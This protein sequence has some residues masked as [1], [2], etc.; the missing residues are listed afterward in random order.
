M[1][2]TPETTGPH[3]NLLRLFRMPWSL[4]DNAYSWLEPTRDCDLDCP[5]C[6]QVHDP[7]SHT[8]LEQFDAEV[9]GLLRLRRTDAVIIAGGEPLTHPHI[10]EIVRRTAARVPKTLLL[11][12]GCKLTSALVRDLKRAGL[13]GFIFHVDKHQNRPSWIGKSE[14][15]INA[16]RQRLADM[17]Y[18][19][20]DLVCG[21]NI[22]IVPDTLEEA[23]EIVRWITS[24]IHKVQM[25]VLIPVRGSPGEG[26]YDAMAGG[27]RIDLSSLPFMR[28]PRYRNM[29]AAELTRQ[30]RQVLPGFQFNSYLAGTLR[31]DVPKWLFG[32]LVGTP[33]EPYGTLGPKAM[34]IFQTIHHVATGRFLS[35][36][37]PWQ[38]RTAQSLFLLAPFDRAIRK[39]LWTYLKRLLRHPARLFRRLHVQTLVVMQPQDVLENG[40]QDL[41]DGCPN[42]TYWQGRLVSECRLE[43]HL[44]FGRLLALARREDRRERSAERDSAREA[45]LVC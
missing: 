34:E 16:L 27:T 45:A 20:G 28:Q 35:F 25:A 18:E 31:S 12:N 29:T 33:D 17:V 26:S 32:N 36:V 44:R 9:D 23:P 19:A 3:E 30:V 15:E 14:R 4:S 37:R 41:C 22:T 1:N 11:T 13:G 43:E 21:F 10:V 2:T 5:Y 38:Y 24:N 39:T 8:T 40:E 6:Y 42:K 7:K